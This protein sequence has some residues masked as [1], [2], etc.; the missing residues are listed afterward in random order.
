VGRRYAKNAAAVFRLKYHVVWCP[1]DRLPVPVKPVAARRKQWLRRKAEPLELTIHQ[2][3]VMPGHV[4]LVVE[5]IPR[6][7]VGGMVS[8]RKGFTSHEL[9]A[10]FRF[11]KSRLPTLWKPKLRCRIGR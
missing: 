2:M 11:L 4:P 10:Q 8:R 1:K 9:R 7:G 6:I 3:Q 5:A